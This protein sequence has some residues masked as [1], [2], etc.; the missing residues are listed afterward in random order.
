VPFP[1]VTV[2]FAIGI[3]FSIVSLAPGGLGIM[4]GS[5][6]TIFHSLGTP[7]EQTV[8]AV[9]LFRVAYYAV[10]FLVSVAFFRTMLRV[11][12]GQSEG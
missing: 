9:L 1:L 7:L 5:M 3:L 6:T 11:A 8:V 2:G 12:R 10:P 4:E